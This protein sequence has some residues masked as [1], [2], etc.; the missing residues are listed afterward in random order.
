MYCFYKLHDVLLR[1][2]AVNSVNMITV[3]MRVC[4]WLT[5]ILLMWRIW[6]APNKANKWQMGFN[7][8]FKGLIKLLSLCKGRICKCLGIFCYLLCHYVLNQ[9]R[10]TC[11]GYK[12]LPQHGIIACL[13]SSV[14]HSSHFSF[15]YCFYSLVS[16]PFLS[17]YAK[18]RKATISF[19]M[20]VRAS[21]WENSA[22]M[23]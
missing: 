1:N 19:V 5:L 17:K 9:F 15:S 11:S 13:E 2:T 23:G 10:A 12:S 21:M 8:A 20:S 7:S 22:P 16:W 4:R 6:W 18:L 14:Y 3:N